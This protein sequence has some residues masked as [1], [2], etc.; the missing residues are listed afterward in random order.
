MK[1]TA[2]N[3]TLWAQQRKPVT[4]SLFPE[5][6]NLSREV[7]NIELSW[8]DSRVFNNQLLLSILFII[9]VEWRSTDD[10]VVRLLH[11]LSY[12]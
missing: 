2:A 12:D 7:V 3:A 4:K 10:K 5:F 6:L 8:V 11:D 1:N 9:Y